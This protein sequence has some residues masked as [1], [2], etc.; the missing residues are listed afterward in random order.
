MQRV[1][2]LIHNNDYENGPRLQAH[3]IF[4]VVNENAIET[5]DINTYPSVCFELENNDYHVYHV[6]LGLEDYTIKLLKTYDRLSDAVDYSKQQYAKFTGKY[7]CSPED[8]EKSVSEISESEDEDDEDYIII[9]NDVDFQ[10]YS[11]NMFSTW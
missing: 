5:Y 1:F 6:R 8:I 11:L 2:T 4:G 9:L 10:A 3:E 7:P